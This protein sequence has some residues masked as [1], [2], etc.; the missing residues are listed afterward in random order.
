MH[1]HRGLISV[2]L[3]LVLVGAARAAAQQG[4]ISG[5]VMDSGT[6]QPLP[7]VQV[8]VLG[9]AGGSIGS[10]TNLSGQFRISLAPGTYTLVAEM[11]GYETERVEGV[12]VAAGQTANVGISLVSRAIVLDPIQVTVGRKVEKATKAP[13]TVAVVSEARI[14]EK[15]VATSIEHMKDVVGVDVINHGVQAGNVVVRGFNNIFS[16]ALHFLTDNRIAGVPS[17]RV[18][19]MHFV[20]STDADVARMEVVLGPGSALY[21]PNTANGVV[22]VLTKSPLEGSNTTIS[23]AGGER[24]IF[25]G[26]LRISRQ[27]SEDFGIKLSGSWFRGE[28]WPFVDPV[29]AAARAAIEDD[30]QS[31]AAGLA[32]LG[33]SQEE[34]KLRMARIGIRDFDIQ[35]W[36][37]EARADWRFASNATAILQVGRT[38]ND[39]IELTGIGAAQAKD[40]TY[41]YYQTRLN[42]G[43]LFAQAYLN[44]SG[45]G[46]SFLLRQGGSLVDKSRMWVAQV[47]HGIGLMDDR[48]DL[49]YGIDYNRTTPDTEGTI[50]GKYEEDDQIREVGAYAQAELEATEMWSLV[51]ALRLDET[52]VLDD[53]VWSPRAALVLTPT[54]GQSL[55]FTYNRAFS[56]PT[57][58]N[59]F[60]DV[61]GGRAPSTLGT[62]GYLTRAMGPGTGGL[63]FQDESG[64]FLGMRSP[65]TPQAAGGPKQLLPVN[66]QT[67]WL[68]G[69]GLLRAQGAIDAQTAAFLSAQNAAA[70][71]VLINVFDPLTGAVSPMG[72]PGAVVP[73][74]P[75]LKKSITTTFELGYQGVIGDRVALAADVWTSKRNNFT[76]PLTLWTPMLVLDRNSLQQFLVSRGLPPAQAGLL[77]AGLGG[78]PEAKQAPAPLAVVSSPDVDALG[79]DLVTTYVNYGEVD[80]WGAD[81]ALTAFLTD[82][83]SLGLTGSLVSDDHFRLRP[84]TPG[85]VEQIV[86]L[87]APTKKGTATLGYRNNVSGFNAEVRAR[88]TDG[89]PANSA[90]FVGTLCV[91]TAEE[92]ARA[93]ASGTLVQDCVDSA[94]IVDLTLG[95]RIPNSGATAQLFVSNLLNTGYQG[96]VGV[97]DI[98]RLA[99]LQLKYEF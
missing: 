42:V 77:A 41:T 45:A 35:R 50:H 71:G 40:W 74:V 4:T 96:F 91:L 73:D 97:P 37:G 78:A 27:L 1:V 89:F 80:L 90:D 76:S 67:L 22:H 13:A 57:T 5:T 24:S 46:E 34:V 30:P 43:R 47:Q 79:A 63:S 68:Y 36:S 56:T 31:Y 9:A 75:I 94:T 98:G 33:L 25:K 20:P 12:Q 65:F 8:Q 59:M 17:L 10:I 2:L 69:V 82:E 55:R 28:E 93:V 39:G 6:G 70:G 87:N 44:T 53:P 88:Y 26:V 32:A 48:L 62:L 64:A 81:V 85:A 23:V 11:I 21:G 54:E 16:G 58:L 83:W 52:S 3:I 66:V 7:D 60:L 61:E 49:I 19:L 86:S 92:R 95:Y 51:G 18:N 84:D 72:T 14:E 99:L 15:V 38:D 29:E